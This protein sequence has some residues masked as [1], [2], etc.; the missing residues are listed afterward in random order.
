MSLAVFISLRQIN[1]DT[2]SKGCTI[3]IGKVVQTGWTQTSKVNMGNGQLFGTNLEWG[4]V[5][6]LTDAD[7]MDLPITNKRRMV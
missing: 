3:S 5:N 2:L 6:N 1:V 7:V 4:F